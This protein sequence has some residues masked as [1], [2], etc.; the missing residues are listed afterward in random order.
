MFCIYWSCACEYYMTDMRER[1]AIIILLLTFLI[2]C[3][4]LLVAQPVQRVGLLAASIFSVSKKYIEQLSGK[5][6]EQ[7]EVIGENTG[8]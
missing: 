3:S 2:Y 5:T 1:T 6:H 8:S 4:L 7:Y